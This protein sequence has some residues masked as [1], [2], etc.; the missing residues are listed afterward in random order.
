MST[1]IYPHKSTIKNL[2]AN[3]LLWF[4]YIIPLLIGVIPYIG[5]FAWVMPT[6]IFFWEK[7]SRFIKF[8]AMQA[9]IINAVLGILNLIYT[10][11]ITGIFINFFNFL[12]LGFISTLI[13]WIFGGL[14]GFISLLLLIFTLIAFIKGLRYQEYE[15]PFIGMIARMMMNLL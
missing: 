5:V 15:I 9:M 11:I 4:I 1:T 6:V 3:Q 14:L 12:H 10:L 13:T 7:Q 2:D 8:E